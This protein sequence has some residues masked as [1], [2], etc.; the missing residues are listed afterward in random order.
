M[1]GIE[2]TPKER[3]NEGWGIEGSRIGNCQSDAG[4]I[5]GTLRK[6]NGEKPGG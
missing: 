4:R 6:S 3:E 1:R 5:K 2:K